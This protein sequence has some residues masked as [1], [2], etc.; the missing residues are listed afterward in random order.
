MAPNAQAKVTAIQNPR[1]ASL[2]HEI[3][4][5]LLYR[6]TQIKQVKTLLPRIA[7]SY[8]RSLNLKLKSQLG[9]SFPEL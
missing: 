4:I 6:D 5:R 2:I 9:H 7:C 8:K 1:L 3:S